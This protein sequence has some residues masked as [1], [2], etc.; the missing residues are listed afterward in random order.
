MVVASRATPGGDRFREF[1]DLA[2][3]GE[4]RSRFVGSLSGVVSVL[5]ARPHGYSRELRTAELGQRG[6]VARGL[7]PDSTIVIGLATEQYVAGKGFSF[8]LAYLHYP[9][10]ADANREVAAR[11]QAELGY[12]KQPRQTSLS[13]D[14]YP[15]AT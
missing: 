8:D 7:R 10:W 2:G 12:F 15:S 1:C 6:Y 11:M 4:R 5:L 3:T 13:E 14:E 9:E